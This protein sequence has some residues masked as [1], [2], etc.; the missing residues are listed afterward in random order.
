MNIL[1]QKSNGAVKLRLK[2]SR[3]RKLT[4]SL[5]QFNHLVSECRVFFEKSSFKQDLRSTNI[6]LQRKKYHLYEEKRGKHISG[7][8]L[9]RK[10]MISWA[11]L[12]YLKEQLHEFE[13]AE[14]E[15]KEFVQDTY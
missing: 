15:R 6:K 8:I 11:Y 5:D 4:F 7:V 14:E 10:M 12:C 1:M 2:S 3:F 13:E 9:H